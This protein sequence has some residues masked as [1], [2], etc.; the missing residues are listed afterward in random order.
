MDIGELASIAR[1]GVAAAAQERRSGTEKARAARSAQLRAQREGRLCVTQD[2]IDT[3]CFM[4]PSAS[5][6]WESVGPL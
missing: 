6:F 1:D 4:L 2:Q 5:N 3:L